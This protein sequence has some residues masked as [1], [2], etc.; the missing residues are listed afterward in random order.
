MNNPKIQMSSAQTEFSRAGGEQ[1]DETP[2]REGCSALSRHHLIPPAKKKTQKRG[3]AQWEPVQNCKLGELEEPCA[4]QTFTGA[5]EICICKGWKGRPAGV[6][7]MTITPPFCFSPLIPAPAR[8]LL[9]CWGFISGP[10][11]LALTV[12]TLTSLSGV[13]YYK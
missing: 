13:N 1:L 3:R 5:A 7:S 4:A 12:F 10:E 2:A 8:N 9:F 6:S 11:P